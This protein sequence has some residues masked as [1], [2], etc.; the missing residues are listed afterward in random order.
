MRMGRRNPIF[1]GRA[2]GPK[3]ETTKVPGRECSIG[4]KGQSTQEDNGRA[5]LQSALRLLSLAGKFQPTELRG[6]I[7]LVW[8]AGR[9][10]CWGLR[11][12]DTNRLELRTVYAHPF[13]LWNPSYEIQQIRKGHQGALSSLHPAVDRMFLNIETLGRCGYPLYAPQKAPKF[14]AWR[15]SQPSFRHPD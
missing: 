10:G 4:T 14:S 11:R 7:C 8:F 2:G 1:D 13:G 12:L 5:D 15:D 9:G 3:R 6:S